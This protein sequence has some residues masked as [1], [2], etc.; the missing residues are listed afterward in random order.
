MRIL[1]L[2]ALSLFCTTACF[3]SRP[4]YSVPTDRQENNLKGDVAVVTSRYININEG[5]DPD[6]PDCNTDFDIVIVSHYNRQGNITL[7]ETFAEGG[8]RLS[9]RDTYVFDETGTRVLNS[10][11]QNLLKN[12][13]SWVHYEYDQA[14]RLEKYYGAGTDWEASYEYG[15]RGYPEKLITIIGDTGRVVTQFEFDRRGQLIREGSVTME[16]DGDVMRLRSGDSFRE[17]YDRNGDMVR[18]VD[19]L[20]DSSHPEVKTWEGITEARYKYDNH[21]NWIRRE[22]YSDGSLYGVWVR[23]IEYFGD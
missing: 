16:Y 15:K 17:E 11:Y 13:I 9:Q 2:T 5:D 23:E 14:G 19:I 6:D 21:G 22:L 1:A 20:T 4:R 18:T 7:E 3:V 10:E 12:S 8:S